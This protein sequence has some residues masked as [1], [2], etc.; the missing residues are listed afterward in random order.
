M[1]PA[2]LTRMSISPASAATLLDRGVAGQVGG[3]GA[4]VDLPLGADVGGGG[5]QRGG[6]AGDE[7]QVASLLGQH[8]GG[9]LADAFRSAGNQDS[10]AREL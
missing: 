6:I 1:A 3:D 7:D 2:L 9:G 4:D 10:F 8:F 5:V